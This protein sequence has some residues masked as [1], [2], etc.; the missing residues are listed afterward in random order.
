METEVSAT[1]PTSVRARAKEW[2]VV[3]E[4]TGCGSDGERVIIG[5]DSESRSESRVGGGE[6]GGGYEARAVFGML[7]VPGSGGVGAGAAVGAGIGA[8]AGFAPRRERARERILRNM[9]S[10]NPTL[11]RWEKG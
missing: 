11:R 5:N 4:G 1:V 10:K 7:A 2:S 8:D 6:G 9:T 3:G